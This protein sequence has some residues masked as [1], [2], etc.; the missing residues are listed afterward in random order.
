[1]TI[2]ITIYLQVLI[3]Q[4]VART[5]SSLTKYNIL[6]FNFKGRVINLVFGAFSAYF[7]YLCTNSNDFWHIYSM[8]KIKKIPQTTFLILRFYGFRRFSGGFCRHNGSQK[9][10]PF[11]YMI[12]R[13]FRTLSAQK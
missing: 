6:H 10:A 13:P 9:I 2:T 11:P 7:L 5:I 8:Y 3:L 4:L 1:M 12:Q